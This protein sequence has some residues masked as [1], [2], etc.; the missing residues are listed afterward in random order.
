MQAELKV[1]TNARKFSGKG[2]IK[3]Q[4]KYEGDVPKK[5]NKSIRHRKKRV[6]F[7]YI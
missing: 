1:M 7:N 2:K 6:L 4:E 3:A 5:S